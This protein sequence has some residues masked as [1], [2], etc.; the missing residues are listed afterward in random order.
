MNQHIL[1]GQFNL[2]SNTALYH[3]IA[4]LPLYKCKYT[5]YAPIVY[6]HAFPTWR[7]YT[8]S[9]AEQAIKL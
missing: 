8:M 7:V 1:A 2:S 9:T 4:S 5:Q 6:T 3:G